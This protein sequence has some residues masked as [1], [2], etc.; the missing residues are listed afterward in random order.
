MVYNNISLFAATYDC[1]AYS[2]GSYNNSTCASA[3]TGSTTGSGTSGLLTNTG[4]DLLLIA[5]IA[6]TIV[7]IALLVRFW[8]KPKTN[9]PTET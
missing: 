4:F 2:S 6:V 7:F 5:T 3:S 1:G 8:K 9:L